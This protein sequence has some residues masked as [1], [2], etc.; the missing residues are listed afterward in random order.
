MYIHSISNTKEAAACECDV[1]TASEHQPRR[2]GIFGGNKATARA[3]NKNHKRST[4][5]IEQRKLCCCCCRLPVVIVFVWCMF[6]YSTL[7]VRW[8]QF[9]GILEGGGGDGN[10]QKPTERID[11]TANKWWR[12]GKKA[13][14]VTFVFGG[15][16]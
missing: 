5:L 10:S 1:T 9:D 4:L 14:Q 13:C 16:I 11:I 2:V 15:N 6:S 7:S 8:L 3:K 12:V